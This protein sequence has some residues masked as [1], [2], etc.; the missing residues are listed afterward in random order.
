MKEGT[1]EKQSTEAKVLAKYGLHSLSCFY[2]N[3][4]E[5][6]LRRAT[7]VS[8]LI[9]ENTILPVYQE[10]RVYP[11]AGWYP[12]LPT[13]DPKKIGMGVSYTGHYRFNPVTAWKFANELDDEF[14]KHII[15][16][17]INDLTVFTSVPCTMRYRHGGVHKVSN[18]QRVLAEGFEGYKKRI[19]RL[20]K[21]AKGLEQDVFY[22]AMLECIDSI[23]AL[24]RRLLGYL[25]KI[26][27]HKQDDPILDNLIKA[28]EQSPVKP[29][30]T[31]YQALLATQFTMCL[32]SFEP[33]RIDKYLYPYFKKDCEE[34]RISI[35]EADQLLEE[36]L[37]NINN[38]G[39]VKHMTLGGTDE[40]GRPVYNEL[41]SLLIKLSGKI[42][43]P[44]TSL[45][46]RKDMPDKLWDIAMENLKNG[47]GNPA[48]INEELYLKGLKETVGVTNEDTADLAFGGCTETLIQGK[49]MTDSTWTAYNLPDILN[50]SINN[51]FI[52]LKSFSEFY[53]S[54]KNDIRLTVKEMTS[55]INLW[56]HHFALYFPL[57]INTLFT[58]DC[59]ERAIG[60]SAGGCRYNFDIVDI[61]G[62]INVINSLHTI[63]LIF[64][65][66]LN[67][68]RPQLLKML[69]DN[70]RNFDKEYIQIKQINKYGN[71][72]DEINNLA[73]DLLGFVFDEIKKYR[74]WRGNGYFL[75][76]VI[77]WTSYI[78]QGKHVE[79][80]PDGRLK[81]EPL[82]DSIG[83]VSETESK[84]LTALLLSAASIPQASALGT[85]ILNIRIDG[86]AFAGPDGNSNLKALFKTYFE[87]G[88]QQIQVNAV[89]T[90]MLEAAL[91]EPKKYTDLVV[92]VAG[93]TDYFINQNDKIKAEIILRTAHKAN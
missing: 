35:H 20:K 61:F 48:I 71:D 93:F 34:G 79:A 9:F 54:F 16:R 10:K 28:L 84:G 5:P 69:N 32:T 1:V 37:S 92:R 4:N 21:K 87:L 3:K 70:F 30:R 72:N 56:Q 31:F 17:I 49:T 86:G 29:A 63:K 23:I 81:A 91:K 19:I 43:Q 6:L 80:T 24:C 50:Q 64:D 25:K 11:G 75:P 88:G 41:T 59:L 89:D 15:T 18:Y 13:D 55:Q 66:K 46:V 68:S 51:Y 42:K 2:S 67:I 22:E 38:L 39:G 44:N 36:F 52:H 77:G 53:K 74:C 83:A 62:A 26:K 90:K 73:K 27:L 78:R 14:D 45:L 7:R 47:R 85:C 8:K 82:S 60:F 58:D 65:N 40:N 12:A 33:G 57:P 76:A